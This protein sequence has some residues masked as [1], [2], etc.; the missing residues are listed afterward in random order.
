MLE[1]G[2]WIDEVAWEE[3]LTG[4]GPGGGLSDVYA[5]PVWQTGAG[6][7]NTR[8]N[9]KRQVPDV[10]A[11]ADPVSGFLT[12]S[13]GDHGSGGGT[14]AAAPFWA[15]LAVLTR[16]LAR[17]GRHGRARPAWQDPV[18]RRRRPAGRH[19]LPRRHPR[20]QPAR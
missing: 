7:A 13:A 9:G 20:R 5:R 12:V 2:T 19:A 8:S 4:W 6:V 10:A 14:S 16:Q 11:A 3:P 17:E 15:G 18:R 1:D